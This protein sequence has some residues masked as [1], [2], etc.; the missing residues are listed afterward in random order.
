MDTRYDWKWNW[1]DWATKHNMKLLGCGANAINT[2]I[3][4]IHL[5]HDDVCFIEIPTREWSYRNWSFFRDNF[6]SRFQI[7]YTKFLTRI[8]HLRIFREF[9]WREREIE[10][11]TVN[12]ADDEMSMMKMMTEKKKMKMQTKERKKNE[13]EL[14]IK[15]RNSITIRNP[16]LLATKRV[17]IAKTMRSSWPHHYCDLIKNSQSHSQQIRLIERKVE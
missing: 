9:A 15:Q 7:T 3:P 11:K 1:N 10:R 2:S 17:V 12:Y 14:H 16:N 8:L 6:F 13:N 4:C 5:M